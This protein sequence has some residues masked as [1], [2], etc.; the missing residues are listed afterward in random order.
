MTSM[1]TDEALKNESLGDKIATDVCTLDAT[2]SCL[3]YPHSESASDAHKAA[4]GWSGS[5][6][7]VARAF[8]GLAEWLEKSEKLTI[9][10]TYT[11]LFDLKP[12]CTL[13]IGHHV[14]GEAY[15]RGA[16]LSGLVAEHRE[17]G[18]D[19]NDELPDYL[20]TVLRL[21]GRLPDTPERTLF[22]E[23]IIGVAVGRMKKQLIQI[24]TPWAHAVSSLADV[25][26]APAEELDD[27]LHK[28]IRLEVLNRA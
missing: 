7:Q 4:V 3:G 28:R 23:R 27:T 16:L 13:D 12:A 1:G 14:Y 21:L 20:P 18:I 25:Y 8:A 5:Y 15:Q 26:I 10:E 11:T 19:L 9:D 22:M 17:H 6:P 24:D 2:A